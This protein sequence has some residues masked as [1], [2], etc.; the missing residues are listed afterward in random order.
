MLNII[1][2]SAIL[3]IALATSVSISPVFAADLNSENVPVTSGFYGG[4]GIEVGRNELLDNGST[5][6]F[7]GSQTLSGHV[8]FFNESNHFFE[9]DGR[10]KQAGQDNSSND[11][12]SSGYLFAARIGQAFDQVSAEIFGG[13]TGGRTDEGSTERW[14]AG[15]GLGYEV[16]EQ[17]ALTGLVGYLDGTKGTDDDGLDGFSEMWHA[18][19][20]V[21]A[22]LTSN[23]DFV[24][25]YTFGHGVMDDDNP[26]DEGGTVS[27]FSVGL[28]FVPPGYEDRESP[29]F[30]LR[31]T[32]SRYEQHVENDAADEERIDVG[33][34][35]AFGQT[36]EFRKK[37]LRPILPRYENWL[38]VSAGVLE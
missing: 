2:Q 31:Y 27:E 16:T 7:S 8:G 35:F 13:F 28:D 1:K 33:I 9:L 26:R 15:V 36:P 38:A 5:E 25:G 37:A 19:V 23:L 4:I 17:I 34:K 11:D 29:V 12:L 24:A 3:S 18:S 10:L 32:N 14:F 20:G 30:T 6:G 22:S 21:Q